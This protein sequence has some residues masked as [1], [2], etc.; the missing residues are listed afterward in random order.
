MAEGRSG[1]AA[2]APGSSI[3]PA[4]RMLVHSSAAM[5][6]DIC[7]GLFGDELDTVAALLDSPVPQLCHNGQVEA[8]Q[9]GRND[10]A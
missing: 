5:T 6:F 10:A 3:P 2:G 9:G 7:A 4:P 8:P 1:W